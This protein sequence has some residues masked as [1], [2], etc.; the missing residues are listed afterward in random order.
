ME[1][2][3]L[4]SIQLLLVKRPLLMKKAK[5]GSSYYLAIGLVIFPVGLLMLFGQP[6][7][8]SL[9]S[10]FMGA[11][12]LEIFGLILQFFGEGL[13]CFGIIGAVSTKVNSNA[14][15]NRQILMATV[16]KNLQDQAA[17][18]N[19]NIQEHVAGITKNFN[20]QIESLHA[21]LNQMQL[22][23]VA[24]VS[25][26]PIKCKF[27]GTKIDQGPFCPSCGKAN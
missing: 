9:F 17:S 19:R 27:C 1:D 6:T 13:I 11:Q 21:K 14:D 10:G 8:V 12:T 16:A 7:V 26:A 18:T 22:A 4:R 24:S 20:G 2:L 15:Y 25:K 3:N 5:I 23:R